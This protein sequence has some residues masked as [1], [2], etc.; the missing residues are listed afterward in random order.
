MR[1]R[2]ARSQPRDRLEEKP[3]VVQLR[4]D[5]IRDLG[6]P[7]HPNLKLVQRKSRRSLGQDADDGVRRSVKR[8]RL[9]EDRRVAV[10]T[11]LPEA[12]ADEYHTLTAGAVLICREIA[13]QHRLEAQRGQQ[14]RRCVKANQL[15]GISPT[16]QRER[17]AGRQRE[18][19]EHLLTLLH[20]EE[21]RI[22]K[23]DARELLLV[24]RRAQP[25]QTVWL[26]I[27]Q[28]PEENRVN[29]AEERH[30]RANS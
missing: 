26:V 9:P 27:R 13:S 25:D 22:G 7:R 19:A 2:D 14:R 18:V 10:E 20:L 21:T 1:Q 4:R 29:Y 17:I 11:L 28:R 30:V 15:L 8:E 24:I 6:R 23:A 5:E 16:S 3:A 12:M